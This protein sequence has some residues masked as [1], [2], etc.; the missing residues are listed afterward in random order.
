MS[1][2]RPDTRSAWL[3]IDGSAITAN[4]YAIRE[5]VG[6]QRL[7][8]AVVKANGYGH[9]AVFVARTVLAAGADRLAVAT[10]DE[11]IELRQAGITAPILLLGEPPI[12]S[13]PYLLE[14][15]ITP[16]ITTIDFALTLGEMADLSGMVAPY[17]L[18]VNTGMNR[19]GI[20]Y[21]EAIEFLNA[22]SF[23]RGLKHEGTY[24]HFATADLIEDWDFKIQLSRFK[25]LI[26]AMKLADIDPG[27]V[28]AA[29]SACTIRYPA[30]YFD[31][32]RP[33]I[34]LY[35]LH[36]SKVTYGKINLKPAMSVHAC[37][38]HVKEPL[39]GEGV[40]YGL[41][42]RCPGNVQIATLP[43]G[44]GDGLS[45]LLSDRMYVLYRGRRV[46]QVGTICMDQMMIEVDYKKSLLNPLPPITVGDEVIIIGEDGGDKLTLDMM[47]D[48]L[49]TINYELACSFGMRLPHI[50][51]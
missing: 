25:E 42:Y 49:G 19:I 26:D 1:S 30:T 12:A 23:H 44:Y 46:P 33:G 47:A 31:M 7:I 45:R 37:V 4:M 5:R 48:E 51:V 21:T 34:M 29:N 2:M 28:H 9:G 41:Q 3:E 24:T 17:H 43:I 40:S 18:K 20:H 6:R 32:V 27:I 14:Y 8:C 10:V 11:A 36:P 35:G 39:V 15:D 38:T 50:Y 13:I 16:T 22:I